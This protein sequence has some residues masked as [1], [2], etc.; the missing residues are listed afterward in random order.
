M[1][2][3]STIATLAL[4]AL[5]TATLCSV[6]VSALPRPSADIPAGSVTAPIPVTGKVHR[7]LKC[8]YSPSQR[9]NVCEIVED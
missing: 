1:R 5:G 4:A 7:I 8:H 3:A 9:K 6:A 2:K